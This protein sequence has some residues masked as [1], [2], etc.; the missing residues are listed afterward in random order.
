M[1]LRMS[2]GAVL[3]ATLA[4]SSGAD[5]VQDQVLPEENGPS[6]D[7]TA[8]RTGND[9]GSGTA[10]DDGTN[11]ATDGG[12]TDGG[13]TGAVAPTNRPPVDE[14]AHMDEL[15]DEQWAEVCDWMIELQGGPHSEECEDG[16]TI[17]INTVEECADEPDRPHCKVELLAECVLQHADDICGPA[18]AACHEFYD[19]AYN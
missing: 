19:C 15:S 4:C 5:D 11:G 14:E 3:L 12:S 18:P 17:T 8:G 9:A 6:G 13:S 2:L 1:M 16:T 7:D 10:G